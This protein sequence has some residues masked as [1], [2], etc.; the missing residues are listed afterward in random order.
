MERIEL[1]EGKVAVESPVQGSLWKV[2]AKVGDVVAE[3]EVLAIAESMKMEIDIEAHEHGKIVSVLCH[4]GENI[5]AGK[6]LFVIEPM[7]K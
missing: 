4:E 3:G 2:F 7:K 5:T 6:L 1:D